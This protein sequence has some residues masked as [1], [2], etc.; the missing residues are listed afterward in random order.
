MDPVPKQNL[1]QQIG[2]PRGKPFAERIPAGFSP[3][4]HSVQP[5]IQQIPDHERDIGRV[6]LSVPVQSRD[7]ITVRLLKALIERRGLAAVFRKPDILQRLQLSADLIGAV[8]GTV[9]DHQNLEIERYA[10]HSGTADLK[11]FLKQFSDTA[12]F[13]IY[14]YDDGKPDLRLLLSYTSVLQHN[15]IPA[16]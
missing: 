12:L 5:L 14:R 3:S 15:H 9:I 1:P 4:G 2:Q 16:A 13:V 7:Q 10:V 11:D 8:R 6:V